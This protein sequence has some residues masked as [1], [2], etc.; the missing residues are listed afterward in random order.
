MAP[1]PV[2]MDFTDGQAS[3]WGLAPEKTWTLPNPQEDPQI[4]LN[5]EE[6]S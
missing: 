2:V 5:S 4:N 3:G 6:P 1:L